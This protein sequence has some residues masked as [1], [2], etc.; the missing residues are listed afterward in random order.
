MWRGREKGEKCRQKKI[1]EGARKKERSRGKRDE[2][3][4]I[5]EKRTVLPKINVVHVF[6]YSFKCQSNVLS[7][8]YDH[9]ILQLFPRFGTVLKKKT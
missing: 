9:Q 2:E 4:Q 3:K 8:F 6:I 5:K 7:C 1:K